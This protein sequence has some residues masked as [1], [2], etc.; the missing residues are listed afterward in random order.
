MKKLELKGGQIRK[1][2]LDGVKLKLTSC[3]LDGKDVLIVTKIPDHIA[4]MANTIQ[5]GVQTTPEVIPLP[6]SRYHLNTKTFTI[7]D[8][9][10][11]GFQKAVN[12]GS[13]EVFKFI[14]KKY[15]L[16]QSEWNKINAALIVS[17]THLYQ[18]IKDEHIAHYNEDYYCHVFQNSV[19][20]GITLNQNSFS[21]NLLSSVVQTV[22]NVVKT[23]SEMARPTLASGRVY[24]AAKFSNEWQGMSIYKK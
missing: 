14:Q 19:Q 23:T 12:K 10:G 20:F 1:T 7:T 13:K 2:G 18:Y 3:A 5:N 4:Q 11:D 8:F 24:I 9:D 17:R 21:G 16:N 15:S 6:G 22:I